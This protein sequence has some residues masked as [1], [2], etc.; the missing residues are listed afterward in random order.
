MNKNLFSLFILFFSFSICATAQWV[1][2]AT[3]TTNIANTN[4]NNVGI[5][6][7]S[8]VNKLH[9][10]GA[11]TLTGSPAIYHNLYY[12]LGYKYAG[13]GYGTGILLNGQGN[14][15][16]DLQTAANN[17][18]GLGATASLT[19]RMFISNTGNIGIGTMNPGNKLEVLGTGRFTGADIAS[20]GV[21]TEVFYTSSGGYLQAYNR[22]TSSF[23][24]LNIQGNIISFGSI[25]N[26][27]SS[28]P[29]L[30][31]ASGKVGIGINNPSHKLDVAAGNGTVNFAGLGA[32]NGAMRFE[33]TG[34]MGSAIKF[35]NAAA[36]IANNGG[37]NELLQFTATGSFVF[38]LGGTAKM[39]INSNGNVGIGTNTPDAL[40]TVNGSV[41]A[42]E[43][44]VNSSIPVP[45]Y[46]FEKKYT[47][48][49][50]A[51]VQKYI[52]KN[53]HLPEIPSA[54]QVEEDGLKL[55]EFN[56]L[57]LKKIEELTLYLIEKDKQLENQK[58]KLNEQKSLYDQLS[59][60]VDVLSKEVNKSKR[61]K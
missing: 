51:D 10:N 3:D 19:S 9:I 22:N 18:G 61:I 5:G 21:G 32:A 30:R 15:G 48:R 1:T 17:T 26:A 8:P 43:V 34:S 13:S 59:Q 58:I 11:I 4:L 42:K 6:T 36:T 55:G 37:S 57:L 23:A 60:K 7:V 40:L 31:I 24:P 38:N 50:L 44:Q 45:D 39:R 16:I 29:D 12:N 47:L 46:V 20:S 27:A 2:T 41:H 35:N 33:G 14:G 56:M 52:I 54:A 25:D 53:K 49:S 28:L